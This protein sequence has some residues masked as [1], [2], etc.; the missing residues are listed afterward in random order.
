MAFEETWLQD[1]SELQFL[2]ADEVL[3][4]LENVLKGVHTL[5]KD[6]SVLD[7]Q[8][9]F[10][11]SLDSEF[12]FVTIS[13]LF[14]FLCLSIFLRRGLLLSFES[15]LSKLTVKEFNLVFNDLWVIVTDTI[16]NMGSLLENHRMGWVTDLKEL[17]LLLHKHA[18]VDEGPT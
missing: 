13:W 7:D 15:S 3:G 14:N 1:V 16:E 8:L 10:L 17:V 4:D 12:T 6:L 9:E 11:V 18:I 2:R 5:D